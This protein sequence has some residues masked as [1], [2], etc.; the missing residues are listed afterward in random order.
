[1]SHSNVRIDTN[2]KNAE[3][4]AKLI[5][6]RDGFL[7]ADTDSIYVRDLDKK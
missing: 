5:T 3:I 1:M 6:I 7:Y 2:L 4:A